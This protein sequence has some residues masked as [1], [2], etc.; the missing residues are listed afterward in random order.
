MLVSFDMDHAFD[1]V[2]HSFLFRVMEQMNFNPRLINFLQ[3]ITR[4]SYSRI[5][6]NG[7]LSRPFQILRSVRQGDPL[8]MLLFVLYIQPLIDKIVSDGLDG[9][10]LNVYADDISIFVPN[11]ARLTQLVNVIKAFEAVSGAV[12]NLTKTVAM[13]IGNVNTTGIPTWLKFEDSYKILGL[14]FS[15][16]VKKSLEL[17]WQKIVKQLKW[18][19]WMCKSRVLN[20][21]QKI[22][23]I[24]TFVSSKLWYVASTFPLPKKFETQILK[25]FR[26]FLWIGG[27]QHIRLETL[28]LPK[29]RGGLNLHSPGLK[30][31]AL[32]TNRMLQNESDLNFFRDMRYN[33]PFFQIP[34]AYPQIKTT[35]LEISTLSP[36]AIQ[37][38]SSYVILQELLEGESDPAIFETQREWRRIFKQLG[39]QKLSSTLRSN[40]YCAVHRKINNNELLH[41][42]HRRDNP[43]C[44]HCPG[45]VDTVEHRLFECRIVSTVWNYARSKLNAINPNLRSKRDEYFLYP[46]LSR[47]S[48]EHSLQTKNIVAKYL[49]FVCNNPVDNLS[50]ENIK[51][52]L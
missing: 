27:K 7:S 20:L 10:A 45:T 21:I 52:E 50:V 37:H 39:D 9:D 14:I 38:P 18:R 4:N 47:M 3:K 26:N 29:S 40:W 44:D 13:K 41:R 23:H 24:N 51:I 2:K 16:T 48:R 46:S 25:E 1:R 30:S 33:T 43:D 32:L 5:L 12:L 11:G 22:I 19:L 6:V 8:S 28:F 15:D 49:Y 42:Q 17:T 34:A 35:V 31:T 36:R